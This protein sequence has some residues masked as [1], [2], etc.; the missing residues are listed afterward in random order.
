MSLRMILI[1]AIMIL[2]VIVLV[3]YTFLRLLAHTLP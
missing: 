1:L 3:N 2:A